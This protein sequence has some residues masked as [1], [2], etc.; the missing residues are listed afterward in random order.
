[1]IKRVAIAVVLWVVALYLAQAG[2]RFFN[3]E[4]GSGGETKGYAENISCSRNW[5][6]FGALWRCDA[7]IVSNE[8]ERFHYSNGSSSLTPT[9]I[10]KRVPMTINP[11]RFSRSY[12]ASD[13]WALAERREPVKALA[14]LSIVIP[15]AIAFLITL[16]M[17][18]KKKPGGAEEQEQ[19]RPNLET[20]P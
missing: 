9:D 20:N 11:V 6:A 7:T 5:W 10:G 19:P 2:P 18:R 4:A 8:G 3:N 16:R 17:F 14:A 15:S 12:A 1:M 13:E